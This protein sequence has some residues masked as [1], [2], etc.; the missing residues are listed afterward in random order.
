MVQIK[1]FISDNTRVLE[2]DVNEFLRE[3]GSQRGKI[4][5]LKDVKINSLHASTLSATVIYNITNITEAQNR[6]TES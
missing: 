2:R 6:M 3:I 1:I 4:V 5:E